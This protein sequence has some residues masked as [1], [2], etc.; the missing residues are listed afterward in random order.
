MENISQAEKSQLELASRQLSAIESNNLTSL[1]NLYTPVKNKL[2]SIANFSVQKDIGN[3]QLS[4]DILNNISLEDIYL[5]PIQR[6]NLASTLQNALKIIKKVEE[7]KQCKDELLK[8]IKF[9]KV[10]GSGSFG[11]VSVGILQTSIRD[12]PPP[13][14]FKKFRFAIKMSRMPANFAPYIELHIMK[15][16]NQ[17]VFERK[18]QNLPVVIDS[19]K[20]DSC[21]FKAKTISNK[22][23][24]CL[25]TINEIAS[26][27]LDGWLK[28]LPPIEELNSCLF[29]VMAG[30]HA[31]QHH[32]LILNNDIKSQNILVYNVNAG[33]YWKYTIYGRDFYV[34]NYG[35]LFIVNDYGISSIYAPR[36]Q[37]EYKQNLRSVGERGF[38]I[39]NNGIEPIQN[40]FIPLQNYNKAQKFKK[41][42]YKVQINGEEINIIETGIDKNGKPDYPP[43]LTSTQKQKLGVDSNNLA[44][45]NSPM[46]P[47]LDFMIDTQDAIKLFYGKH[48]RMSQPNFHTN[49]D[50]DNEFKKSLLNNLTK[51]DS[52]IVQKIK[53]VNVE[54]PKVLAGFFILDHFTRVVNYTIPKSGDLIISHIQTS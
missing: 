18:A 50:I 36:F 32:Y 11:E 26:M 5:N 28:T 19:Y 30:I 16:L 45:Y 46:V 34:P 12:L 15:L 33:G 52:Y 29:Q 21:A 48:K 25:F 47:S 44:F 14:Y 24:K 35:K 43:I 3:V 51:N 1:Q 53:G 2:I 42:S 9:T 37:V 17:L 40:K 10:L 6:K 38:M 39:N 8:H 49:Y 22:K 23:N 41:S 31:L 20:C 54:L 4:L 13:S 27:D 7:G